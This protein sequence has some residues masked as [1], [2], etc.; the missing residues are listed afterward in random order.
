MA[1]AMDAAT[2]PAMLLLADGRF[3]S[4]GHAHSAGAEAAATLE[5]VRDIATLEEFVRGRLATSGAVAAAFA[6]AACAATS[7]GGELTVLD[8]EF[9]ARTPSPALRRAAHRLGR[10][11]LR[12]GRSIWPDSRLD[13][14]SGAGPGAPPVRGPY[15]PVAFGA[16]AAV[17]GLSPQGTAWACAHDAVLTPAT[18]AVRLLGLDPYAVH[19]TVAR[20]GDRITAVAEAAA[21]HTESPPAELPAYSGPLLDVSAERHATW[22]VR[23]FAS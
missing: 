3:P 16:V 14:L 12:A 1:A 6:A 7:K 8:A 19:R 13:A 5:G 20:L 10:Q 23:L 11:V 22:E 18:A 17:A 9:A 4:G 15:Q 2:F 21:R